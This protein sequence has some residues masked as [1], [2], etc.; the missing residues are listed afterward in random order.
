VADRFDAGASGKGRVMPEVPEKRQ[1][2]R[3]PRQLL[4]AALVAL[5][6]LAAVWVAVAV[7]TREECPADRQ[8]GAVSGRC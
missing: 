6:L 5:A 8:T 4:L 1:S 7:A 2:V 3:P